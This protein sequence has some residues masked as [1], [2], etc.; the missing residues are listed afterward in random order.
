MEPR[1]ESVR[2]RAVRTALLAGTVVFVLDGIFALCLQ[3]AYTGHSNPLRMFQGIARGLLGE[4]SFDAGY[5]SGAVGVALH[6]MF[7]TWWASLFVAA[8]VLS[9]AFAGLARRRAWVVGALYGPLA[10]FAMNWIAKPIGGIEPTPLA[11]R[12][13]LIM[14]VGHAAFV[15]LPIA[16]LVRARLLDPRPQPGG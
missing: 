4:A 11:T 7:A 5:A 8:C 12:F 14:S 6:W 15:G 1:P 3:L 10:W 2:H 13:F 16:L 9:A